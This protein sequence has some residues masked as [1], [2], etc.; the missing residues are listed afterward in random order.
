MTRSEKQVIKARTEELTKQGVA[1][2][3]AEVMAK[4][5]LETGII[6]TVVNY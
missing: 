3:I 5:E 2:E 6:R 1:K 4:A